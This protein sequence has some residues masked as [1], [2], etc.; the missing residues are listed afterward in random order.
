MP[1]AIPVTADNFIRAET[2][3]Y[4]GNIA[5]DGGFG[6][7][8]HNREPTPVDHQTVLRQNRD[9]LYSGAVFDLD[10]GPVTITLPEAGKRFM[11]MQLFDED[12]YTLKVAYGAGQHTL[13]RQGVGTR[14]AMVA[15]R[16]LVD[17]ND[18]KD[19]EQVHALQDAV[20]VEQKA[21]GK[22]ETPNWDAKSQ[23]EVRDALLKLGASLA[24]TKRMFGTKDQVDPVRRLIGAATAWGGNPETEA[25]YLN[26]TPK[27][28]DGKT[29]YRLNVNDVPVD[30][31]WSAIVYDAK[32]YIP[33][34]ERGVYSFNNITA[35]KDADGGVTIQFGGDPAKAP[36][37]IPIVP[38]WNYLVRL[39]R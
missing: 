22:F 33:K 14:Y 38:G 26:V 2:D 10:A 25:L 11:S 15:L 37:C 16:T 12:E 9:T 30:G 19:I 28:N 34:N 24:D 17:A 39:Y 31:F 13:T 18:P 7:F 4:F 8:H 6:K 27:Q 29:V 1:A 21:T 36:N 32:G 23:G 20:K 35:K 3:L 5:K